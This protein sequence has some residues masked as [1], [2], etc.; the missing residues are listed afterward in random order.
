M[1]LKNREVFP[2][3]QRG[4]RTNPACGGKR[5]NAEPREGRDRSLPFTDTTLSWKIKRL[6]KLRFQNS[7]NPLT[8]LP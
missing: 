2:K 4:L 3:S 5:V 6:Q 1:E 8:I 7:G